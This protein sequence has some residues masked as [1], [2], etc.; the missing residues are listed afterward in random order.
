MDYN[1]LL[2]K[3]MAMNV[4]KIAAG[5]CTALKYVTR[6]DD[7]FGKFFAGTVCGFAGLFFLRDA[8]KYYMQA[9]FIGKNS[10]K[11]INQV[12]EYVENCFGP[13]CNK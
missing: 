3:I 11:T 4:K 7:A 6:N 12:A 8:A 1:Q 5:V 9:Y 13:D 2:E 10:C